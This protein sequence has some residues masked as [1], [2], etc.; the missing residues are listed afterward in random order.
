M[1]AEFAVANLTFVAHVEFATVTFAKF[2]FAN[3]AFTTFASVKFAL[4]TSSLR[5]CVYN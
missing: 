2:A 1:F 5:I 3:F 4:L